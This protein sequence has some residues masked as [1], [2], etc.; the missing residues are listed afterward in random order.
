MAKR[1]PQAPRCRSEPDNACSISFDPGAAVNPW[2]AQVHRFPFWSRALQSKL[3][4]ARTYISRPDRE[5]PAFEEVQANGQGLCRTLAAFRR[6]QRVSS[7]VEPV[8]FTATAGGRPRRQF[9]QQRE[10]RS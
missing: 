6:G 9:N 8:Y 1:A 10:A 4:S 5:R 2:L 3:T 7:A